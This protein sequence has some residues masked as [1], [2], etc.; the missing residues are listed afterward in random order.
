MQTF[1]MV[2]P[3]LK[4]Q[5]ENLKLLIDL[6]EENYRTALQSQTDFTILKRLRNNI[7]TLKGDLQVLLDKQ[8]V[9]ET[10]DLPGGGEK[11]AD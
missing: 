11:P 6:E 5:I 8:S 2:D 3:E 7:K 4:V 1:F 10:G 9:D